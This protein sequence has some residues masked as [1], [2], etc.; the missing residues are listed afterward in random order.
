MSNISLFRILV[1]ALL[2]LILVVTLLWLV[3][4]NDQTPP[5]PFSPAHGFAVPD[6]AELAVAEIRSVPAWIEAMGEVRPVGEIMVGAQVQARVEQVRVRTGQLVTRGDVLALLDDRE[7][8][9]RSAQVEQEMEALAAV[10]RQAELERKATQAALDLARADFDRITTLHADGAAATQELDQ[11]RAS[12]LRAEAATGQADQAIPELEAQLRR[13]EHL[14]TELDV[15]LDHTRIVAPSDGVVAR[16]AIEPGD[17]A[18][19]GMT[20]FV[21]HSPE[22]RLEV[23]VP[24]RFHDRLN[25]GREFMVRVDALDQDFSAV[26]EEREPD[27]H[28]QTRTFLVKLR[29]HALVAPTEFKKDD[30]TTVGTGSKTKLQG[31]MF[32]RLRIPLAEDPTVVIP[33]A[34]LLRIGQ[35]ETAA[36]VQ[37]KTY[38]L[39]HLRLGQK[40]GDHVEVLSGLDGGERLWLHPLRTP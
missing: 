21:L 3:F 35:L 27:A 26:V 25:L 16:R 40:H 34:A 31:G 22:L 11:A 17:I 10:R 7:F 5:L 12:F 28:P 4:R 39:R 29:L 20:L 18:R 19:P 2:A 6:N 9:A 36:V 33:Q 38:S 30:A 32:A 8:S 23:Q 24:E 13:L 15:A 1:G 37:D 14:A